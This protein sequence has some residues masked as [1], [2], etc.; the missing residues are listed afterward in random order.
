MSAFPSGCVV[1]ITAGMS[2]GIRGVVVGDAKSSFDGRTPDLEVK[3]ED[4]R[5]R[6]IRHDYLRRLDTGPQHVAGAE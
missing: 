2:K 1:E 6:T 4:G 3:T 5:V